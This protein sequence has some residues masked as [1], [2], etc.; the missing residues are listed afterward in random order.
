MQE[1]ISLV[2][3]ATAKSQCAGV[4]AKFNLRFR[5]RRKLFSVF[6]TG[7]HEEPLALT[8]RAHRSSWWRTR[9][10]VGR[11]MALFG[12]RPHHGSVRGGCRTFPIESP[13]SQTGNTAIRRRAKEEGPPPDL[14]A[15]TLRSEQRPRAKTRLI[16][17]RRRRQTRQQPFFFPPPSLYG[18]EEGGLS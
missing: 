3:R 6:Y 14:R 16:L 12:S 7:I 10:L 5:K 2:G 11:P 4:G 17:R 15:P 8:G 9:N 1:R 13:T 18:I